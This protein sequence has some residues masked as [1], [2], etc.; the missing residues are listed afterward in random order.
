MK[1][2]AR[3]DRT[4]KPFDEIYW[5]SRLRENL[6]SGS[7]GEGLETGLRSTLNGHAGGNPGYSQGRSY[8]LPRQS[9]T[10]QIA[11]DEIKTHQCATLRG[12]APTVLRSKTADLVEQELYAVLIAYNL[13]REL[14][15]QAALVHHKRPRQLSFLDALQEL[16]DALPHMSIARPAHAER[17]YHYLIFLIAECE[18]DRP[19]RPR[20]NPRVVKVKMSKF[21]RKR[22]IHKSSYRDIENELQILTPTAA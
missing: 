15:H 16:I 12:Q 13:V 9:F 21:K 20:I 22:P 8:E 11:F 1:V 18:I 17:Q 19:Q 10:R 14:I 5:V 3:S 4:H 2:A 6:T 7:N